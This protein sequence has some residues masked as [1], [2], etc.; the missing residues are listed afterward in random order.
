MQS[1]FQT[2]AAVSTARGKGGV[3]MIRISGDEAHSVAAKM[4]IPAGIGDIRDLGLRHALYGKICDG[5]E[6][7]DT[8]ICTLYGSGASFTGEDTAEICCHGGVA[9]TAAV[10]RAAFSAGAVQAGAGEFTRRAFINGRLSL[11]EAEAVGSLIDADTESRRKLAAEAAGGALRRRCAEISEKLTAT[12]AALYA[13][14]DYP[15]EDIGDEGEREIAAAVGAAA[16]DTDALLSTYR[17]GK[18][19]MAG[20]TTVICGS[21]NCGKSSLYNALLG[22]DRAIVTSIAGTTRDILR[23]TVDIGGV[24]LLLSDTAGLRDGCDEVEKIGVERARRAMD[25]AEILLCV[26]DGS[27][28]LTEEECDLM[29]APAAG[30]KLAVINKSDL[31]P[32]LSDEELELIRKNHRCVVKISAKSSAGMDSLAEAIGKMYDAGD[33]DGGAVVWEARQAAE[34]RRAS[35]L[36]HEAH[37]AL[38]AGEAPDG[39]CTLCEAALAALGMVDGRDVTESIVSEIFSKFCV[40]K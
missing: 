31:A 30:A 24:T 4:F 9:V 10:L 21:P 11:T 18:A 40:G 17:R 2:I 3:A 22:E 6:I 19:V 23:D 32:E 27:R 25:E 15:D 28:H 20:V 12:M 38:M 33:T 16:A 13:A 36:L 7:L 5:E 26:Y 37:D 8:G 39:A 14:V 34:L 29:R 1:E 35:K